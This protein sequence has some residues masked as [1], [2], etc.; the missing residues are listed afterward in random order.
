MPTWPFNSDKIKTPARVGSLECVCTGCE[1][2]PQMG[3]PWHGAAVTVPA[4]SL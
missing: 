4:L 3:D 2:S 1:A